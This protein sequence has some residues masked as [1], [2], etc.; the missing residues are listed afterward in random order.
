[1]AVFR[2]WQLC[3][4]LLRTEQLSCALPH[5]A[6]A[7]IP[8]ESPPPRAE[9]KMR[10][11]LLKPANAKHDAMEGGIDPRILII[12]RAIGQQIAREQH[13]SLQAANDNKPANAR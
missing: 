3:L 5:K 8:D 9:G 6:V 11:P 12:A 7:M 2:H 10:N 1:M 4:D 13:D